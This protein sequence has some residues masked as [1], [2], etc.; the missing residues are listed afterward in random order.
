MPDLNDESAS[1][2]I[3]LPRNAEHEALHSPAMWNRYSV[4]MVPV[5]VG[6]MIVQGVFSLL[7]PAEESGLEDIANI[8][9]WCVVAWIAMQ[10]PGRYLAMLGGMVYLALMLAVVAWLDWRFRPDMFSNWDTFWEI[11]LPVVFWF[12]IKGLVL[13]RLA[14]LLSGLEIIGATSSIR[15]RWGIRRWL[16]LMAVIAIGI[17]ATVAES[18]WMVDLAGIPLDNMVGPPALNPLESARS[19]WLVFLLASLLLVPILPVH[20]SGWMFAGKR[21]RFY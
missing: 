8:P 5:C 17:Q 6:L 12:L 4:R 9:I 15:P 10:G 3:G 1:D 19:Q 13:F 18:N 2:P 14:S 11:D 7:K 16:L 20:F 21:W